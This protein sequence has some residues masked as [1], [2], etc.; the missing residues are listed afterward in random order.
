LTLTD[1]DPKETF[2]SAYKPPVLMFPT[3]Q[4]YVC[5]CI[6]MYNLYYM[7]S[8]DRCFHIFYVSC[9]HILYVLMFPTNQMVN[10]NMYLYVRW[11]WVQFPWIALQHASTCFRG[12][13]IYEYVLVMLY[14]C[15]CICMRV[16]LFVYSM[17]LFIIKYTDIYMFKYDNICI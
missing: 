17:H 9:S 5:I 8:Y 1:H 12:I 7:F 14:V 10:S 13:Y 15:I 16:Y 2:V 3:N 11:I 4:V 6:Y